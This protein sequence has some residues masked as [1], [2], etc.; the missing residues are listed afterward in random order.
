MGGA[1]VLRAGVPALLTGGSHL[2]CVDLSLREGEPESTSLGPRPGFPETAPARGKRED[3]GPHRHVGASGQK[4]G[5]WAGAGPCVAASSRW[6]KGVWSCWGMS[7][8]PS[9]LRTPRNWTPTRPGTL[10]SAGPWPQ[11]WDKA[12]VWAAWLGGRW[13]GP[14]PGPGSGRGQGSCIG[15]GRGGLRTGAESPRA[16]PHRGLAW[17]LSVSW[18]FSFGPAGNIRG[19]VRAAMRG[20]PRTDCSGC[21]P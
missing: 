3:S 17:A 7:P 13:A 5:V 4:A 1:P 19:M 6:G 15:A 21:S 9:Y 18:D 2:H 16:G 20:T 14:L 11:P 8:H 12:S 10:P